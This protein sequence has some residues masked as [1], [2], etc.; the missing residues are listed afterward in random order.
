M[1]IVSSRW[2]CLVAAVVALQPARGQSPADRRALQLFRDSL[3][4]TTDTMPMHAWESALIT[5]ARAH[6]DDAMLHLRLGFLA[7]RM[8]QAGAAAERV[9][10]AESEF[11]WATQLAPAWPYAWFGLGE[12][13]ASE[14]DRARG[15]AG[16]LYT[17]TGADR[18]TRA[19]T[20][21]LH[22][23]R[24]DPTFVDGLTA[25][26]DM[27]QQQRLHPPIAA[28]LNALRTVQA[29]PLGWDPVLLVERG[30]L[31]RL[32]GNPDSAATAFRRAVELSP[33]PAMAQYELARTL[34]LVED[35]AS[36]VDHAPE[37]AAAYFGAVASDEPAVA[38]LV[39]RDIEPICDSA[40][41]AAFDATSGAARVAWLRTFWSDLA[42]ADL[43]SVGDRI[44]EHFR[45]WAY[46]RQHFRLPPFKRD[47]RWGIEVYQSGDEELDDRGIIWL[48]QGAPTDRIVWPQSMPRSADGPTIQTAV[49][50]DTTEALSSTP[51]R[52]RSIF[53]HTPPPAGSLIIDPEV[54]VTPSYGNETWRY[55]RSGG[56]LVLNFAAVDDPADYRLVDDILDLD[57]S[58]DALAHRSREIPGLGELLNSGPG[59]RVLLRNNERLRGRHDIALA[60]S[61]SSWER[62]YPVTL[63][64]S[65]TWLDAGVRHGESLVH[66][67][68]TLS[69][70]ALHA[71]PTDS[72]GTIPIRVRAAMIGTDRH[73]A[74]R[75]DTVEHLAPPASGSGATLVH[76]EFA[77]PSGELESHLAIEANRHVGA[78]FPADSLRVPDP[79]GR[80]LAVSSLVLGTREASV[81]WIA[82]PGDTVW[83]SPFNQYRSDDTV[84]LYAQAYGLV[85]G[86]P[87]AIRVAFTRQRSA[88]MRFLKGHRETITLTEQLHP[89]AP[90][91]TIERRVALELLDP[92]RYQVDLIVDGGGSRAVARNEVEIQ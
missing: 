74:A 23:L 61:S 92:G 54:G 21:F 27:A 78:V 1:K 60:T 88:L 86:R 75:L 85:P 10:D 14:P 66:V 65:V 26:A 41:M 5:E 31:E 33:D 16:G 11:E 25:F 3:L 46:V 70:A 87:Y 12:A 82:A 43:R 67:V 73:V 76:A 45:R 24:A 18:D 30:R 28:A 62:G 7:L 34:P 51:R 80:A 91:A 63:P 20:A 44:G 55:A 17:M 69:A 13:Y 52:R 83:M 40:Q 84:S 90:T 89:D 2:A 36:S 48:R 72:T 57:V 35:S 29:S 56:D 50:F 81:P 77:V 37:I 38:A 6:R 71:L 22:A 4:L 79:E 39:R 42:A 8:H 53:T 64:A 32:A 19:G 59:T 68:Y 9:G 47:Y 15:F 58:Y 49:V